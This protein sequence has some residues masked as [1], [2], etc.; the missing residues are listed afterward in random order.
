SVPCPTIAIPHDSQR[1][2]SAWIAHSK[3]SNVCDFP[4]TTTSKV[5]SYWLLHD[6]QTAMASSRSARRCVQSSCNECALTSPSESVTTPPRAGGRLCLPAPP[7][8]AKPWE[9]PRA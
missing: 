9:P 3:L 8:A 7:D 1:G 4:A 6:S 2:A 5:L